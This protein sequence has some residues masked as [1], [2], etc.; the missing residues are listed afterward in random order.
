MQVKFI[1]MPSGELRQPS[2]LYDPQS[3]V[4]RELFQN[5]ATIFPPPEFATPEWLPVPDGPHTSPDYHP[6]GSQRRADRLADGVSWGR[7]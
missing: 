5:D 2:Q 7:C 1:E 6:D 4:L 3:D